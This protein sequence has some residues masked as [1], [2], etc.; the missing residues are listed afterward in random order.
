MTMGEKH[1]SLAGRPLG[2]AQYGLPFQRAMMSRDRKG[3]V[4]FSKMHRFRQ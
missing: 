3:A 1:R 4:P 2:P